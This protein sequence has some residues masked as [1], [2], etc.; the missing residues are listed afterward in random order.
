[1][2]ESLILAFNYNFGSQWEYCKRQGWIFIVANAVAKYVISIKTA[3]F[4]YQNFNKSINL[5]FTKITGKKQDIILS[6]KGADFEL[7]I[8]RLNNEHTEMEFYHFLCI[9]NPLL[10]QLG[11]TPILA[12]IVAIKMFKNSNTFYL[13]FS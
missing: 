9:F 7:L 8:V 5:C 6:G 1:M 12:V 4:Y 13:V 2:I 10:L 3:R 11:P